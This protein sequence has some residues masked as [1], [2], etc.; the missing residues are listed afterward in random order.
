MAQSHSSESEWSPQLPCLLHGVRATEG[1]FTQRFYSADLRHRDKQCPHF[2]SRGSQ[3]NNRWL[4][5]LSRGP[6]L[7]S[8]SFFVRKAW[9]SI[10]SWHS[11]AGRNKVWFDS[12]LRRIWGLCFDSFDLWKW[13]TGDC[14]LLVIAYS[15][16]GA[17]TSARR[18]E[19]FASENVCLCFWKVN[20]VVVTRSAWKQHAER[21]DRNLRG[22]YSRVLNHK[23]ANKSRCHGAGRGG[24]FEYCVYS[25]Q[26]PVVLPL[27]LHEIWVYKGKCM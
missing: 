21:E 6:T 22:C 14:L 20:K 26:I 13:K 5:G 7:T 16:T 4:T 8:L 9:S 11:G 17:Q 27:R 12:S 24:K 1:V 15:D 25:Q 23:H 3:L 2:L 10:S 19:D 18:H